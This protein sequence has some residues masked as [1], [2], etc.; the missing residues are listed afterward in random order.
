MKK[1]FFLSGILILIFTAGCEEISNV[2]INLQHKEF[3]VVQAELKADNDFEGVL[4]TKTLP[5]D[6]VYD[7]KK[8]E[9]NN[10]TAFIKVNGTQV[11]P[12]HYVTDGLYKPLDDIRI[13]PGSFYE[14]FVRING[15]SVYAKTYV[16]AKPII[17]DA[18]YRDGLFLSGDIIPKEN[19]SYGALWVIIRGQN[20]I[21]ESSDFFSVVASPTTPLNMSIPVRTQDIAEEYRNDIYS[22]STY[23]KIVALDI[24]YVDFFKTKDNNK[25]IENSLTSGGGSVDWN[26]VGEDA[27]GLFIGLAEG[28]LIKP[29]IE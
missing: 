17:E 3:I 7:I 11:I 24:S 1:I 29:Q 4:I 2:E 20:I 10:A 19:E 6:Q 18:V 23:L 21:S 13:K 9:I 16:P 8:V 12:I 27:I 14:L 15:K 5:V 26:V 22:G 28:D 25:P